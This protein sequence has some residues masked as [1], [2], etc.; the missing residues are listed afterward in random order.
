[1]NYSCNST[2]KISPVVVEA[3]P[4]AAKLNRRRFMRMMTVGAGALAVQ[5]CGGGGGAGAA[6]TP[7]SLATTQ[8]VQ[9]A[10]APTEPV[11]APSHPPIPPEWTWASIPT[12]SFTQGV[13][14]SIS[15]SQYIVGENSAAATITL[16][17][18]ALP[19]GVV[20]NSINRSF[21]YDG[22]GAVNTTDGHVL[23]IDGA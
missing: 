11:T 14:S 21:D 20:F 10:P 16:N 17:E 2:N 6:N 7:Q 1:M 4:E 3:T 22:I 5:A 15:I 18:M 8:L 23:T 12:L 9:P 19:P 13:A